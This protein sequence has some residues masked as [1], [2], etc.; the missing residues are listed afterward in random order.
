MNMK[1]RTRRI[2]SLINLGDVD[3][4]PVGKPLCPYCNRGR[5]IRKEWI[6]RQIWDL[7]KEP[8]TVRTK[9]YACQVCGRTFIH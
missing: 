4:E 5:V 9:R 2:N 6:E 7:G 3:A 1:E 8:I